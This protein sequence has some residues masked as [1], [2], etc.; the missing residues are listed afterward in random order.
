MGGTFLSQLPN[1][2][3]SVTNAGEVKWIPE[4][5]IFT[6]CHV[7]L[8]DFPF[9]EQECFIEI[10]TWIYTKDKVKLNYHKGTVVKLVQKLA[11]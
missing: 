6:V 3:V 2:P 7:N 5:L 8:N 10:S 1:I 4:T 11:L 9:D